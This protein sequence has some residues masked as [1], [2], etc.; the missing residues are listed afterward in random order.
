MKRIL[1]LVEL[2]IYLVSI[3]ICVLLYTIGSH[4]WL[5]V[6]YPLSVI[7]MFMLLTVTGMKRSVDLDMEEN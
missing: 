1:N 7:L 2:A 6:V 4:E 5:K 3:T